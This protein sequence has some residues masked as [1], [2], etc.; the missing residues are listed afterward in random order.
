MGKTRV[1][2]RKPPADWRKVASQDRWILYHRLTADGQGWH[3]FVLRHEDGRY[4][5]A[6][7]WGGWNGQRLAH[8]SDL[9]ILKEHYPEIYRWLESTCRQRWPVNELVE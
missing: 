2:A 8:N 4:R 6:S 7:F 9:D 1:K 5:K 3:N